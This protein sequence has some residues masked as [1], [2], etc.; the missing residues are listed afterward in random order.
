M[1]LL[2]EVTEIKSI[3]PEGGWNVGHLANLGILLSCDGFSLRLDLRNLNLLFD[4]AEEGE[5]GELRD[6]EGQIIEIQPNDDGIIIVPRDEPG[7]AA[8][9]VLDLG[10]LKEMGIEQYE[11]ETPD[12]V[13][14]KSEFDL[15]EP[16]DTIGLDGESESQFE[17][18][19][20]GIKRAYR[21]VGK[22]I[23]R[24][25]RV[26]SGFRKGRVVSSAAGAFRPRAKASTRLKLKLAARK[27]KVMRIL[28]GKRT[29]RKSSSMRLVRMNKSTK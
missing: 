5:Y 19:D 14:P 21:R 18:L 6:H 2:R 17:A 10:T 28:K 16:D 4:F 8:G 27:K 11:E 23:K 7:F 1:R 25:F 3:T 13:D 24:G 9:L 22:K 15:L 20:E 29:R 26:T 12:E